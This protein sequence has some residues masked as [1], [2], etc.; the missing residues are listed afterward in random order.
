M[1]IHTDHYAIC[2]ECR[3]KT[4]TFSRKR[5]LQSRLDEDGWKTTL[6]GA[7]CPGCNDDEDREFAEA[8]CGEESCP[9]GKN[10]TT[11]DS[12]PKRTIGSDCPW[13]ECDGE[14]VRADEQ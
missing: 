1:T 9:F 7:V 4:G 2:K 12:P 6:M 3:H 8:V 11:R 10:E 13:N 14:L 5:G